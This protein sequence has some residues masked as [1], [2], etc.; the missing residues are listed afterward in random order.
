MHVQ[1]TL[2][3]VDCAK[4]AA[5]VAV[6]V[7]GVIVLNLYLLRAEANFLTEVLDTLLQRV[8]FVHGLILSEK[9]LD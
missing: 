9:W 7:S 4:R 8:E 5:G 1:K 3:Y 2:A 6:H